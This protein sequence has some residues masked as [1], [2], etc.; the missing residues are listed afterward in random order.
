MSKMYITAEFLKIRIRFLHRLGREDRI[1]LVEHLIK[2]LPKIR[3]L[4]VE[5]ESYVSENYFILWCKI[6]DLLFKGVVPPTYNIQNGVEV[7]TTSSITFMWFCLPELLKYFPENSLYDDGGWF[8]DNNA[9]LT[10]LQEILK[11]LQE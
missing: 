4:C 11:K 8:R 5:I 3:F 10:A 1:K 9:R 7:N 6:T 2:N